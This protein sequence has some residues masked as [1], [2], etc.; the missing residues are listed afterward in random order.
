MRGLAGIL[1]AGM[2]CLTPVT[3]YVNAE[4]QGYVQT[5]ERSTEFYEGN[6]EEHSGE[7]DTG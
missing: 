5:A 3:S 7:V 2:M 6:A 4:E 1:A